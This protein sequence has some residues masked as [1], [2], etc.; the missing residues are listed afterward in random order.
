MNSNEIIAALRAGAVLVTVNNRL[1][2]H[3]RTVFFK[4]AVQEATLWPTPQ[5]MPWGAWLRQLWTDASW[6]SANAPILLGP[7]QA[8]L[9]WQTIV[10][11]D[12]SA[13]LQSRASARLAQEAWRLLHDWQLSLPFEALECSEDVLHFQ[14]WAQQFAAECRQQNWLDEARLSVS[15][16]E[17]WQ[18]GQGTLPAQVL[19]LGFEDW[20]PAQ[21]GLLDGLR[22]RGTLVEVVPTAQAS[23][24]Q[25]ARRVALPD[26]A[27][28]DEA[29]ARWSRA[30]LEHT[31][32]AR[33]AIIAP[34]LRDRRAR[35]ARLLDAQLAPQ[36]LLPATSSASQE[37]ASLWN[38]SLG[39]A[40]SEHGMVQAALLVFGL[41]D[42]R[43][44]MVL[45]GQALRSPFFG[46]YLEEREARAMLD[47]RL[48]QQGELQ[49][50]ESFVRKQAV[51]HDCPQFA[52][53]VA[54]L[55]KARKEQAARLSPGEWVEAFRDELKIAAWPGV[56]SLSSSDFQ[57]RQTWLDTLQSLARLELVQAKMR[58]SEVLAHLR[59][60]AAETLF[61][62]EAVADAPVQVLGP[63]ESLGLTFDG[64][65][66][67]G[68]QHEQ[69]PVQAKPNPFLPMRLQVRLA[70]PHASPAR[71]LDYAR[72]VGSHLLGLAG[73]DCMVIVSHALQA[74]GRELEPS[75]LFEALPLI[76]LSD[77]PQSA[78][79]LPAYWGA[80]ETMEFLSEA[81][82][83]SLAWGTKVGGGARVLELQSACAFRAFAELRLAAQAM[84]EPGLGP[85]ARERGNLLH[86]V[87]EALWGELGD[88][89]AL[90]SLNTADLQACVLRHV[91]AV[92]EELARRHASL[93]PARLQTLEVVR[94]SELVLAWLAI[95]GERPPFTV[96]ARELKQSIEIGGLQLDVKIDRIDRIAG[97]DDGLLNKRLVIDYKTGTAKPTQWAGERP[98]APQLP[99][100]AVSAENVSALAF[101][102]VR[103]GEM[104]F[105]GLADA[106]GGDSGLA[107]A[108]QDW[109]EVLAEY[110][111]VLEA[112]AKD[113]RNG[114]A[115]V[116]PRKPGV[117]A[118]CPLTMLCR[119]HEQAGEA[120]AL[121]TALD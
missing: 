95:E 59:A 7:A 74:D 108:Q 43:L 5:I 106:Q 32:T 103:S 87:M 100:Y 104:A 50:S 83:P 86:K 55:V 65:W 119:I 13:L 4:A 37:A 26:A 117:C 80:P 16:L 62:P 19:L 92:V 93:W 121:E 27:S 24:A 70:M 3:W 118:Y 15:M 94:L 101:A 60:L 2:R 78:L 42:T 63:L 46:G 77:L 84:E 114:Q 75:A 85:D 10:E 112:L 38:M 28:E 49:L 105:A 88:Q 71:E 57:L 47:V 1:A 73:K 113:Y 18:R 107:V 29:A 25:Q 52:R 96:E 69:W 48:R 30:V 110:R 20:T 12:S 36:R 53:I 120:F 89:A 115:E 14:H 9:L 51:E 102:Q 79:P 31:P 34:D 45:L 91:R 21:R 40:L 81:P 22:A 17:A 97:E 23:Q 6:L 8:A 61:Q 99:L 11:R 66:L 116:D 72:R 68:M 56:V 41:G 35:L 82:V 111:R 109:S 54:A 58:R 98:E 67:L 44:D 64:V 39:A 33:L 90:L 76:D